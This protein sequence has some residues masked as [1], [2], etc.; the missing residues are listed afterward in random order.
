MRIS[1]RALLE[2]VKKKT[3]NMGPHL[4]YTILNSDQTG[5]LITVGSIQET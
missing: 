4:N 2:A 1:N 5:N 3:Y